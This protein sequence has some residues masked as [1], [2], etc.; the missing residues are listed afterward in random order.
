VEPDPLTRT[1]LPAG[2]NWKDA[3]ESTAA[4]FPADQTA[5]APPEWTTAAVKEGGKVGGWRGRK[6]RE[7]VSFGEDH[8]WVVLE[9]YRVVPGEMVM[10]VPEIVEMMTA[11]NNTKESSS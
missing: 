5:G 7:K 9:A 1:R 11:E 6:W 8:D 2:R 3:A 4:P 10:V